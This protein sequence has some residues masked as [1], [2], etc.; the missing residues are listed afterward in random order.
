MANFDLPRAEYTRALPSWQL[1]KDCVAGSKAVK[2]R[3]VKYLPKPDPTNSSKENEERYAALKKRAMFLN[4]TARTED[5]LIGAMF[6][7]TAELKLP[8]SVEYLKDNATGSGM[9]LE[10]LSKTA[11]GEC[12]ETGRGGFFADYPVVNDSTDGVQSRTAADKRS[13]NVVFYDA[14]SIIDWETESVDDVQQLVY[15][16]LSEKISEFSHLDY[17]RTDICQNRIL[18]MADGVYH[19]RIYRDGNQVSDNIPTDFNGKPFDHIPFWFVGAKTNTADIDKAPLEDLA[20]VN[21]LHYGN[22][23]TV[24]ESGFISSQPTL[25]FT[26]DI[27]QQDFAKWN[28]NGIQVGSTTGYSLG[29]TGTAILVQAEAGQLARELMKDKEDQMLMIG[30][31]IV[32]KS[33]GQETAEAARM[34][35]GSDN[36]ILSTIAGNVSEALKSAILDA[37]RFKMQEPQPEETTFWLPQE[38]FD[39]VMDAQMIL[40]QVQLWQQG[41]IAK[42]DLRVNLRQAAILESDRTDKDIDADREKEPPIDISGG[43]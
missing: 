35:Y 16:N 7:K 10:Q 38:Y 33:G 43:E 41:I 32:Q 26:T 25:F 12:L 24:E 15:V 40:A 11:V 30:A 9:S 36:S 39:E 8:G 17:Q 29:K 6:R 4:V 13:A 42:S 27:S 2:A 19:Q 23:A 14:L 31:R 20:E 22:S 28:P 34:R 5:G 3:G 18:V 37:Q 1:V 21:I